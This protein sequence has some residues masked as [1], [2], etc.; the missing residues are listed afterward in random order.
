MEMQE[1]LDRLNEG[2]NPLALTIKKW[3]DILEGGRDYLG[4]NC[5]LCGEY[6]EPRDKAKKEWCK[7]CPVYKFVKSNLSEEELKDEKTN[8]RLYGCA[9]TPYTDWRKHHS[10]AHPKPSLRDLPGGLTI[11]CDI[12]RVIAEAE[13]KFLKKLEQ[14]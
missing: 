13:L 4:E 2:E 14:K 7:G 11:Q 6:R 3:E 8:P 10:I 12:C 9:R 1:M 5:A